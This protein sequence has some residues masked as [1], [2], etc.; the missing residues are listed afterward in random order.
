MWSVKSAV[1][2]DTGVTHY[3]VLEGDRDLTMAEVVHLWR[4]SE[5]F[6]DFFTRCLADSGYSAFKWEL[7]PV[8]RQT[9]GRD[10]QFVLVERP[11]LAKRSPDFKPF[12]GP[13]KASGES[14]NVC[15]FPNLS[16]DATMIV[17]KPM[18][19][20]GTAPYVDIASFLR[21]A[22]EKQ[23]RE[24]WRKIGEAVEACVS[25]SPLWLN[26]AGGGV[27]WLHVRLDTRP[28]YNAYQPFKE[29]G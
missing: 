28:K 26:T 22:P 21:G 25:D 19:L 8:T 4:E 2:G 14:G 3:R 23:R 1:L 17:P 12:A 7:P 15:V 27:S 16:G 18:L 9:M 29:F 13:V 6:G 20:K 5:A 24:L 11:F 10:F